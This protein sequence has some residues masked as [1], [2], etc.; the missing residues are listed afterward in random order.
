MAV[1]GRKSL[2]ALICIFAPFAA[3]GDDFERDDPGARQEARARW[4]G[5]SSFSVLE[6]AARERD[7]YAM[8]G[9][10]GVSMLSTFGPVQG[11]TFINLGPESADFEVNG[12]G[13]YFEIDSGRA[14]Q[15]VPHPWD[16]NILYLS[17]ATGGVWK[18]YDAGDGWEPITDALG[19]TAIGALAMDPS[20]PDILYLGFGD[21]FDVPQPGLV[22]SSDGGATWSQP[23]QLVTV[24]DQSRS[25]SIIPDLKV[26]PRN[27]AVVLAATDVGLFRSVDAGASWRQVALSTSNPSETFFFV[28]SLAW[29]GADTW[30]ATGQ[31]ADPSQPSSTRHN[32]GKFAL[33]RST[34]DGAT[35]TYN[36][37]ALPNGD[38]QT[39]SVGRGTL[40]VAASTLVDP[41]TTRVFLLTATVRGDQTY[42]LFRSDDAG[43]SFLGVGLNS[44]HSPTNPIIPDQVDLD[45]L[46]IQGWYNQAVAVDPR[47]P[48]R[49]VVG[50]DVAM[51]Q[52]MDAG[53]TWSVITDWL[54]APQGLSLPYVH[55]DLHSLAF[56]ADG[57]LY[58]GSDG[59]LSASTATGFTSAKNAGLVTHQ[60]YSVAC[61]PETWPASLQGFVAGGLQ[62]NG[63]RLR[64]GDGTTF[65]Q[66]LGGDGI[67]VAV[68]A[69]AA[70][71]VPDAILGSS[72]GKMFRSTNGGSSWTDLTRNG[73]FG[74]DRLPF[75]VRI[76]RDTASA[77]GQTFVTYTGTPTK[78][79]QSVGGAGWVDISGYLLWPDGNIKQ[80]FLT[81]PGGTIELRNIATHPAVSGVYG[82]VSNKYAYVTA[83]GGMNWTVSTQPAPLGTPSGTGVYQL[84]SIAFDPRDTTG[85]TY[86]VASNAMRLSNADGTAFPPLPQSF[87][88][89]YKTIDGG[90]TWTSLGAQDVNS[91]GLPFVPVEVVKVDPGD[92]NTLYA[93]TDLGLYRSIDGGATWSRFGGGTLP[94][95]EVDGLCISP[96]SSRLTV[97]TYGRGFWQIGTGGTDPAG[98]RGSG[99][100]NF[101][102]RIDG[103]D[104]I[105]LSDALG[106]TQS[107]PL[108]RWQADL[109]GT[110][111]AI[112]TSDRDALLAKFG[113]TP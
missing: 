47:N 11:N 65:N 75:F 86:Y 62:D 95:V 4:R 17:T 87:G 40:A 33:W 55:A 20:N 88:H 105:D 90:K 18:S 101:D 81:P 92:P 99:D 12:P 100:T 1:S 38:A 7:R 16:K 107:S 61:A 110:V 76:A 44:N 54:P 8:S 83:N 34:D 98:V 58:T 25:S 19:T 63:T 5:E 52:S 91:G 70:T 94:L 26:D 69:G 48:D 14:R 111:N 93:G 39:A 103:L 80:G 29:V 71:G 56:G 74:S 112:D 31:V 73:A 102:Q 36:G 45:V 59:G 67:D 66:V 72:P 35:W 13:Q 43:L 21:P 49:V 97:A 89:L 42:D 46:H 10:P 96:A 50:G 53:A 60:A 68:S 2:I 28:W 22:K 3:A 84:S 85:K 79:Y 109:V 6:A 108:Y 64:T 30:L 23:V 27:S 24:G 77:D 9:K 15:V 82:V 57:T 106:T 104:L 37:S 78:V 113:G 41:A 51:V 32:V